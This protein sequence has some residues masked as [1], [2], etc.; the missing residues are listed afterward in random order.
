MKIM[1]LSLCP[2]VFFAL[3]AFLFPKSI[4]DTEHRKIAE[5][6]LVFTNVGFIGI[7]ILRGLYGA[8]GA[9]YCAFYMLGFYSMIWTWGVAIFARGRSDIRLTWKKA[10]GTIPSLI[11]LLLYLLPVSIPIS[12]IQ[13]CSYL[14]GLCTPISLLITGANLARRK[15]RQML[16]SVSIYTQNLMKLAV[17]PMVTTSVLWA[18]GLP[19]LYVILGCIM[20]AMPTG[21]T[22]TMFAELYEI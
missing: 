21:A 11:G 20:A 18:L 5:F 1:L 6:S 3:I 17:I 12:V 15:L 2:R 10:L 22:L 19:D 14:A 7:P 8:D 9:F 4:R 13:T 16:H